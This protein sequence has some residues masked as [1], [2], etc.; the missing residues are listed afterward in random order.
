MQAIARVN[1][2]WRDKPGG[3][4]VDYIGIGPEL[5]RAIAEYAN[6]TKAAEPPVDFIDSAVP[7][8]VETV[9]V[10]RDMYHGFD[11]SRFRRSQQD[12][13]AV[14]APA[15]NHIATFDPGDDGHGRNRGI[16]RY[17]DQTTR[18]ARLQALCG[19]HP[20]AVALREEIG[21]FLAVRS[22]LVKAT[23]T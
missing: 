7:M 5:R 16:K 8:L 1:R 19:T 10:I 21:F 22:M 17:V 9:G 18:L 14:L 11:Y 4:V 3:L 15:A 13:L 2:V 6:L 20:D 23:R 12:M